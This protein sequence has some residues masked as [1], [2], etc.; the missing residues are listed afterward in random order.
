MVRKKSPLVTIINKRTIFIFKI[1]SLLLPLNHFPILLYFFQFSRGQG[2]LHRLFF[3]T[4]CMY[5]YTRVCVC[6]GKSFTVTRPLLISYKS[7][8]VL[9]YVTSSSQKG[10]MKRL[11]PLELETISIKV[12]LS[13]VPSSRWVPTSHFPLGDDHELSS[14]TKK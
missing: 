12:P 13:S 3:G 6:V 5:V 1:F 14:S 11:V 2:S 10:W 7:P 4:L 9:Y 8:V